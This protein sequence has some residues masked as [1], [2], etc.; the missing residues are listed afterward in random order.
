MKKFI[1]FLLLL[2]INIGLSAQSPTDDCTAGTIGTNQT[3]CSGEDPD[4]I[5]QSSAGTGTGTLT[6][7]WQSSTTD[8]T[9]ETGFTNINPAVTTLSYDPPA[10]NTTTYYRRKDTW[11]DGNGN[12]CTKYTN[13]VTITVNPL[14]TLGGAS[15][16]AAVCAGTGATINMTGLLVSTTFTVDYTIN[17]FA[18]T[19]ITG[20]SSNSSGAASFI[21]TNLTS[22]NNGQTLQITKLT[23]TTPATGCSADFTKEVTLAV[24]PLPTLSATGTNPPGCAQNGTI[25]FTFSN[26]PNG[27]YSINYN[28]NGVFNNVYVNGGSGSVNTPQ[29]NYFNLNITANNC[30]SVPDPNNEP[31]N[32]DDVILTDPNPPVVA[33]QGDGP[34]CSMSTLDLT[35]SPVD[36][37]T[38]VLW[39][40]NN[41]TVATVDD[42]GVVTGVLAGTAIITYRYTNSNNC[43]AQITKNIVVNATPNISNAAITQPIPQCGGT[44]QITIT[45]SIQSGY[46]QQFALTPT[47][48]PNDIWQNSNVFTVLAGTYI[49]KAR[50]A[51]ALGCIDT[52]TNIQIDNPP[53][54]EAFSISNA[55]SKCLGSDVQVTIPALNYNRQL[56]YNLT[57]TNNHSNLTVDVNSGVSVFI[58]PK[59]KLTNPGSTTITILSI[60]NLQTNCINTNPLPVITKQ[61]EVYPLPTAQFSLPVNKACKKSLPWL[62]VDGIPSGGSGTY[63]Q[64]AWTGT[65]AQYLTN[66]V[67]EN[68]QFKTNIE[69]S[70]ILNYQVTDSRGCV[71]L[72]SQPN[73][74]IIHPL[75]VASPIASAYEVCQKSGDINLHGNPSG[76]TTPYSHKWTGTDKLSNTSL[77]S[78]SF[79]TS[80]SGN[81]LLKYIVT[82]NNSCKDTSEINIKVNPKPQAEYS[83]RKDDNYISGDKL[84]VGR[85]YY[86]ESFSKSFENDTISDFNWTFNNSNPEYSNSNKKI[87]QNRFKKTG[88]A[89]V[90]LIVHNKNCLDTLAKTFSI[91]DDPIADIKIGCNGIVP[92]F[93]KGNIICFDGSGSSPGDGET[94]VDYEWKVDNVI[95]S[96][97][98][99]IEKQFSDLLIHTIS[100]RIKDSGGLWSGVSTVTI[101]MSELK[102]NANINNFSICQNEGKINLLN[103]ATGNDKQYMQFEEAM[104]INASEKTFDPTKIEF[105]NADSVK[106]SVKYTVQVGN[107]IGKT[108]Q[109][110]ITVYKS[111]PLN[112]QVLNIDTTFCKGDTLILISDPEWTWKP[113][114][115]SLINNANKKA[116]FILESKNSK[117]SLS[118]TLKYQNRTCIVK[119]EKS[120]LVNSNPFIPKLLLPDLCKGRD[121]ASL[122]VSLNENEF[123]EW[124]QN[125]FIDTI[126]LNSKYR[127]FPEESTYFPFSITN[128]LTTCSSDSLLNIKVIK[129]EPTIIPL[130]SC[131]NNIGSIFA[132]KPGSVSNP[133]NI[134]WSLKEQSKGSINSG[135]GTKA[136]I[137][138]WQDNSLSEIKVHVDEG[139]CPGEGWITPKS[140]QKFMPKGDTSLVFERCGSVIFNKDTSCSQYYLGYVDHGTGQYVRVN[141]SKHYFVDTSRLESSE[142]TYFINCSDCSE[143]DIITYREIRDNF[144]KPCDEPVEAKIFVVPNPSSGEFDLFYEGDYLGVL[145]YEIFNTLGRKIIQGSFAKKNY[146]EKLKLRIDSNAGIYYLRI[147]DSNNNVSI[148]PIA[149]TR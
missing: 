57:G 51:N 69:G 61:F 111:D 145:N 50:N 62:S 7:Q 141:S 121:T 110:D 53:L 65:G 131:G 147:I 59:D 21:T 103:I 34:V 107:C 75:P 84:Q 88:I 66:T 94:I 15:Q 1:P 139:D 74:I 82:D 27:S 134:I 83:V 126:I 132:I 18:Q 114:G 99:I 6:F 116:Q 78:P 130:D 45:S 144:G 90:N 20:V 35:G 85:W 136:I 122:I 124:G 25:N 43:S 54:P 97:N 29:G 44:G 80:N 95:L 140:G 76:G 87:I 100:L 11:D 86:F 104:G 12:T 24:N 56:V 91:S 109:F 125:E 55:E 16:Q 93:C 92:I 33:I 146:L 119:D 26:V 71:S 142:R 37:G 4:E 19:A 14:P 32:D 129:V 115:M 101:Q 106:I 118:D 17:G 77:E 9:T 128:A 41:P 148:K 38:G 133:G 47:G 10:I 73:T 60:K 89:E 96:N 52:F 143:T 23:V 39:T 137:V 72:I 48:S 13:C 79:N 98:N 2:A 81:F 64:H 28:T 49:P 127:F 112:I 68:P 3:I 149:I 135:Q 67:I 8:C 58:I 123:I 138:D 30:T 22:S 5:T 117:L 108:G 113:S 40:S 46:N 63:N 105:N 102:N 36:Q 42:Y 31:N 120:F 70:F